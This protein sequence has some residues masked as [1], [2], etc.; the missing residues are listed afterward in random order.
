MCNEPIFLFTFLF[1]FFFLFIETI[2][3]SIRFK[4]IFCSKKKKRKYYDRAIVMFHCEE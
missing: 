1:F 2:H 3:L 4:K